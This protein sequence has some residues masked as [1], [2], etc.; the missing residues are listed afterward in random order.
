MTEEYLETMVRLACEIADA[1][2]GSL[3]IVDGDVLRPYI[4]YNLPEE[5]I[6]G[7]GEVRIGTQCCGR[8]VAHK[9]PWIV[10]DML[11]DPLFAEGRV[12]AANSF[13]RAAFSVPVFAGPTVVASLACHFPKPHTPTPL[14]I[15]RNEH[16]A[17]LIAITI[18]DREL[19]PR[20]SP[21][22]LPREKITAGRIGDPQ[23]SLVN[24]AE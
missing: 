19:R 10:T 16:F 7:I 18:K 2:S 4:I 13:I 21:I 24:L 14:D 23:P 6:A 1:Q 5:Y 20:L 8:A 3:F 9:K 15:E 12:G 11:Q 17:K 22:T